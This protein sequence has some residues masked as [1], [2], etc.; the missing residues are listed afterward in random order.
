MFVE[1]GRK[2]GRSTSCIH[3]FHVCTHSVVFRSQSNFHGFQAQVKPKLLRST[4]CVQMTSETVVYL[5]FISFPTQ[6]IDHEIGLWAILEHQYILRLYGTVEGFGPFRAFVSPWMPNGSLNS[7]LSCAEL[8]VMDRLSM[9]S[10]FAMPVTIFYSFL[11]SLNKSWKGLS[12]V[13]NMNS[14]RKQLI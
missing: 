7:Y 12:I 4:V 6:N 13:S 2:S 1:Q 3:I 11:N 8:T 5:N 14:S 9:V 10:L